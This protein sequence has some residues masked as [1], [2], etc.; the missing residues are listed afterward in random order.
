MDIE[1]KIDSTCAKPKL[2]IR[3]AEVNEEVETLLRV[4]G[5]RGAILSGFRG[6][7]FEILEPERIVRVYAAAQKVFAV[8]DGGEY[9]L[10]YRLYELEERL[11]PTRFV[12]ISNSEIVNLRHTKSFSLSFAGTI[13]INL[14]NGE[15]SYVS[16]RYV[17]K[18]KQI[19]G[20]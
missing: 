4:L 6:D 17:Q 13:S 11:D 12:R 7:T 18:I 14:S 1:I 20:V 3:C 8:T 9:T 10:R 5:S 15:T 19:L 2:Q 16:R